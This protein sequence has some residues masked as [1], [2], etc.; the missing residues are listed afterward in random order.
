MVSLLTIE[1]IFQD[2]S[3][4]AKGKAAMIGDWLIQGELSLDELIG[5]AERQ[6]AADKASCIEAIEYATKNKP[7]IS[8][9]YLLE[10]VIGALADDEPRVKWE[11]AKVIGNIIGYHPDQVGA[12]A[13]ALLLNIPRGGTV[14]RWATAYALGE[15]LKLDTAYNAF[16]ILKVKELCAQEEDNGVR[17]K[18]LAAFKKLKV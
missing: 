11:S 3:I 15:I 17:N 12:A 5:Y 6:K 9:D 4:K 18:Y 1:Q 13:D 2:K 7:T 14:L 8:D 10:Y 16:L